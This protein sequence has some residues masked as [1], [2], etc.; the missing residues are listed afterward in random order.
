M[1]NK[2][3]EQIALKQAHKDS[4]KTKRRAEPTL[5]RE[6]AKINPKPTILIVCEG[7]N[8]E[9]SYFRQFKLSSATIKPVGEGYNTISLVKRALQL[10]KEK[11]YDQVWCVFDTDPKPDNPNQSKNFNSA[12]KLAN[13]NAFGVAYSNQ[14][15]EYWIILHLD[16]HQGGAMNRSDYNAKINL[17]L[18]PFG[19]TYK[20]DSSKIVT[21]EIFEV[22]D[23]T[24]TKTNKER[25]RLAILRAKKI[26]NR[27]NHSNPAKEESSTTV[28][29]L[30]EE[31]LKY[32]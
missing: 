8:T 14:A 21:E 2:K 13:K 10:S 27:L 11:S 5:D 6:E 3:A 16:D 12:V 26:Y 32:A 19:L 30:V 22:L 18:K 1:K 31:L 15:F 23:G 29:R 7:E 28:F 20:G 24:D 9:P 17:L 25:K 4:L